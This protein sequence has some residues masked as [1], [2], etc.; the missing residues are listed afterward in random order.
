[1]FCGKDVWNRFQRVQYMYWIRVQ[2]TYLER[3]DL[4]FSETAENE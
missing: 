1:M 2:Y 3:V 4:E